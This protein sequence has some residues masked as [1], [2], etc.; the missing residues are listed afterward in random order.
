MMRIC[1][2]RSPVGNSTGLGDDPLVMLF[3]NSPA[4]ICTADYR[5]LGFRASLI[6][7]LKTSFPVNWHCVSTDRASDSDAIMTCHDI[8]QNLLLIQP[9]L[10]PCDVARLCLM[11]L[12]Q[13]E[14]VEQLKDKDQLLRAWKSASFRLEAAADQH[15]AVADELDRMC[16]DGPIRF[17]PDQLWTLL[18]AVKVQGQLLELY[19]DFPAMA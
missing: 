8:A 7:N 11:I 10:S 19:T 6:S 1:N 14:N 3:G 16:A 13:C 15:A 17:S 4:L 9:D 12:N 2:T 18:R 5:V